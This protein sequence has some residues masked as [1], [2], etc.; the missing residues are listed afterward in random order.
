MA[1]KHSHTATMATWP[2]PFFQGLQAAAQPFFVQTPY[3][4]C[5]YD[6][7]TGAYGPP[8]NPAAFMATNM[9]PHPQQQPAAPTAPP[10]HLPA[11]VALPA[12]LN[13]AAIPAAPAV[14]PPIAPPPPPPPIVSVEQSEFSP[15]E[16]HGRSARCHVEEAVASSPRSSPNASAHQ[17]HT[18]RRHC[19]RWR[20]PRSRSHW[21]WKDSLYA[22]G[23]HI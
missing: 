2:P 10:P 6:P 16:R 13:R 8:I 9:L 1:K 11:A 3:G 4:V 19:L 17:R 20:S 14:P 18:A 12:T 5:L 7:S 23:L 22:H 15:L 21:W